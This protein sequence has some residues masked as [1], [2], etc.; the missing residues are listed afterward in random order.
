[1][2]TLEAITEA[3]TAIWLDDLSQG[4]L[5]DPTSAHS[6]ARLIADSN[7]RG[8]TTNPSIFAAALANSELYAEAFAKLRASGA[9]VDEAIRDVTTN[10]VRSACDLLA[11]VFDLTNGRDGRVSIEVDARNAHKTAESISEARELW[12]IVDRKN[13]FIKIPGTVEGLPAIRTL[14]SEGISINI[15]LIFS[16]ERHRQVL[17]AYLSGLEDRVTAG[18]PLPGIQ[19]VASFFVSR[20]DT[21]VDRQ[22][23]VLNS[24]SV[25]AVR[26]KA[27]I[28]NARLAYEAFET[29]TSSPRWQRLA[30]LGANRQ[31]PLWASTGVKDKTYDDTRYVIEL[32][33]PD[34]VNTIPEATLLAVA[35]HGIMRGNTIAGTYD[36]SRADLAALNPLGV[37]YDQV[38]N[39][40][41]VDGI[42]KF[43]AAWVGLLKTVAEVMK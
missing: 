22:L 6:L 5:V 25:R 33:A 8:V 13:L 38:V 11:G 28:A 26:G 34:T 36:Q 21:E 43:E 3:G 27:A 41:E 14:T 32:V 23:D 31:R 2:N 20:V 9:T 17:D 16:L 1:M 18:L 37:S 42:A 40:L 35:D 19:S 10:D 7:V 15:T 29:I 12:R 39:F 24:D 4:R 30:E